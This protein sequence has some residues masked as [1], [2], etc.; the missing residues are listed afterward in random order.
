MLYKFYSLNDPFTN[1]IRYIG[2][3]TLSVKARFAQHKCAANRDKPKTYVAKWFR[4]VVLKGELPIM[5]IVLIYECNDDSWESIEKS[6]I[7]SHP[8]LTNIHE[9]G[10]GIAKGE[11]ILTSNSNKKPVVQIH[12]W[13]NIILKEYP[14]AYEAEMAVSNKT[15][16]KISNVISQTC[17]GKH[18]YS[19][20]YRWSYLDPIVFSPPLPYF[21]VYDNNNNLILEAPH[22]NA[23]RDKLTWLFNNYNSFTI[24]KTL[25]TVS[26]EDD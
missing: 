21:F 13:K 25:P 3:T 7:A 10:K 16:D 11:R 19:F 22:K 9:G 8:N 18:A 2:V 4:S 6:L 12:P 5:H 20:G 15:K 14:S 26:I 24:T 1:E 17:N 23:I